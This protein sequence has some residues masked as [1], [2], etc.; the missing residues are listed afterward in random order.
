MWNAFVDFTV[1]AAR[2]NSPFYGIFVVATMV[3][4]GAILGGIGEGILWALGIKPGQ[5]R[6]SDAAKGINQR[7]D[8]SV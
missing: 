1:E 8:P 2:S 3:A 6:D 7:G 4:L 5:S